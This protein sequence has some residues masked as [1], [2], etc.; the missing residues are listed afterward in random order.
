M[1]FEY[2]SQQIGIKNP[3]REE[4][5]FYIL[6]GLVAC[7]LGIIL[8]LGI[9]EQVAS[10]ARDIA[11]FQLGVGFILFVIGGWATGIGLLK[12][13]RFFIG[14]GVP[15]DLASSNQGLGQPSYDAG[16]LADMLMARKNPTFR[17]PIGVLARAHFTLFPKMIFLPLPIRVVALRLSQAMTH[18]GLAIVLY[19]LAIFSGST[20]L[21]EIT[22]TPVGDW[23]TAGLT[24]ALLLIWT[25]AIPSNA[26]MTDPPSEVGS[27]VWL[28][29]VVFAAI[30][31]PIALLQIH[32]AQPLPVVPIDVRAI[33]WVAAGAA[34]GVWAAGF[35]LMG[36]R[37]TVP[38]PLTE[39][40]EYKQ[41]WQQSL[42]P[43]D[44]FRAFETTMADHRY[45][46][47]PNRIYIDVDAGLAMEGGFDRGS[48]R[49]ST[50]VETQPRPIA[51]PVPGPYTACR[52]TI[53]GLAQA[54]HLAAAVILYLRADQAVSLTP[55][56]LYDIAAL[57]AVLALFA[58]VLARSATVYLAEIPFKSDIAHF[59]AD[60]TY[61]E[62]KV[63]S[64][65]SVY[66]SNRSENV[67]VRSSLTPWLLSAEITT[68]TF[69]VSGTHN[70]EQGRLVLDMRRNETFLGSLLGDLDQY[71]KTRSTI[72][73]VTQADVAA[74]SDFQALNQGARAA[75]AAG[76][77][78]PA[79]Q[80]PTLPSGPP[81]AIARQA[82]AA[83]E[84]T[85][86]GAAPVAGDSQVM[87]RILRGKN[88]GDVVPIPYASATIG[89][90][91]TNT[92]V[93]SDAR[94][95]RV[96]AEVAYE[97]DG[98]VARDRGS[99]NGTQLNGQPLT[100]A[101]MN[102]G[103]V[104]TIGD[105]DLLLTCAGLEYE[106]KNP[107]RSL[108]AYRAMLAAAPGFAEVRNRVVAV[109]QAGRVG[110]GQSDVSTLNGFRSGVDADADI[111]D[112]NGGS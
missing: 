89:R 88:A 65:M 99:T 48:F 58:T 78:G 82:N 87:I 103:D 54:L 2:G 70:L 94:S 32:A 37:L 105:T 30:L 74:A 4:G 77:G 76:L 75:P 46:E 69:A 97:G 22:G 47:I 111:A 31:L 60:G 106:E 90:V 36:F 27:I 79:A 38:A 63:S 34:V 62:S 86:V 51:L 13:L 15:S 91:E 80:A 50:L 96:H 42:H 57:P 28:A 35:V 49:G 40:A 21:T 33:P 29:F 1:T 18:T 7:G 3:F 41:H 52:L 43:R 59:F 68:V 100:E 6:R 67:V 64:G 81:P 23:L 108:E 104:I 84:E 12:S 19:A 9:R 8:A 73:G 45:L 95:S 102:L 11:W 10:G 66:D 26:D 55:Q 39:V 112:L 14:R 56:G 44:I 110:F 109:E 20:G 71:M 93:I 107:R 101:R 72:A 53:A 83:E 24:A 85:M 16:T 17:E 5:V 61:T 92:V 25:A 98:F